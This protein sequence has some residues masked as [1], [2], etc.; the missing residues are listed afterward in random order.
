VQAIYIYI[1]GETEENGRKRKKEEKK[2]RR[3]RL[4]EY[5]GI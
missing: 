1:S 3:C 2:E 5:A 4:K